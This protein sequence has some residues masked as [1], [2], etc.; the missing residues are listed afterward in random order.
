MKYFTPF[1]KGRQLLP[2]GSVSPAFEK[3]RKYFHDIVISHG[4]VF[5]PL[6]K[7]A[8]SQQTCFVLYTCTLNICYF[9]ELHTFGTFSSMFYK[10]GNFCDMFVFLNGKSLLKKGSTLKRE[11]IIDGVGVVLDKKYKS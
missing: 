2:K 7:I 4:G 3:A 8:T 1:C 5:I 9:R 10:G 11:K 6:N